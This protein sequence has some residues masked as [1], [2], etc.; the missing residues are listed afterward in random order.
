MIRKL[1][2]AALSLV[3][4][5]LFA[6]D[7]GVSISIGDPNF[8]GHIEFGN[9]A[10]PEVIYREPIIIKKRRSLV[11]VE[12]IYLRVR[13]GHEKHWRKHCHE[14]NACN[15]PVYFVRDTWYQ[16][17]YASHYR[18]HERIREERRQERRRDR[19]EYEDDRRSDRDRKRH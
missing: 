17:R 19:R 14:Y 10:R 5:P 15:R 12:P 6:A 13:P 2:A 4:A 16:K 11:R 7:V 1:F 3:A 8:Y 18:K 9:T